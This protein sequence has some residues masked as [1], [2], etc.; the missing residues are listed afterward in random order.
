[1]AHENEQWKDELY[2]DELRGV[3]EPGP[4]RAI[5]EVVREY[6]SGPVENPGFGDAWIDLTTRQSVQLHWF[7]LELGDAAGGSTTRGSGADSVGPHGE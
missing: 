1:M 5:G 7:E 6:A 4:L 2:S 3:L